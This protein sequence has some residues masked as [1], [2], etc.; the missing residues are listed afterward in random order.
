MKNTLGSLLLFCLII[1]KLFTE[2][3]TYT[4]KVDKEHAYLK[5]ALFLSIDLNQTNPDIVL[6]FKFSILPSP[7]YRV[8]Q[9]DE[10][11][12][13]ELHHTQQHYLFQLYPLKTGRFPV[14]FK[15]TK[16][17]TDEHKVAYSASG[18][19]DDFKK[20]ETAD[21][22][23]QL[24]PVWLNVSPLPDHTQ[25]IGSYHLNYHFKTHRAETYEPIPLKI[26]I[27]GRGFPPLLKSI[28]PEGKDWTL[29]SQKPLLHKTLQ[30]NGIYYRAEYDLALSGT[31]DFDLPEITL[32]GFDPKTAKHYHLTIPSQHFEII[33]PKTSN[34]IDKVD[35]PPPFKTD[36]RWLTTLLGY[37]IVFGAG[38]ASGW[39]VKWQRKVR[40]NHTH[41]LIEKIET[42]KEKRALLQ[43]L[44]AHNAARFA[45]V[46]DK[47]E[48]DLYGRGSHS[49]TSLK[50]EAKEKLA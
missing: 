40:H 48:A 44:L 3:F 35:N 5:E 12:I 24:P 21:T 20:L 39:L 42:C 26:T 49:L 45:G 32:N 31:Q 9:I 43:L 8:V 33:Q 7:D 46:I 2:D 19:R 37:L 29:F 47:L 4:I 15:L 18:D 6:L 36:W 22:H 41:P 1:S 14:K 25:L 34:L 38:F 13:A 50:R 28:I 17:V 23:I 10:S 30:P 27:E 11:N 16:R